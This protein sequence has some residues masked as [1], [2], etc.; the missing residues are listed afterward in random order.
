MLKRGGPEETNPLRVPL[1]GSQLRS[2]DPVSWSKSAY[3]DL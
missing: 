2:D 1:G 3:A